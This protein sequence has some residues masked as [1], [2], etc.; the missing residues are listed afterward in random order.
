MK[1]LVTISLLVA[2]PLAVL[3]WVSH[4]VDAGLKK[5]KLPYSAI[6]EIFNGQVNADDF[7]AGDDREEH[8]DLDV[9]L[10]F[11]DVVG[12]VV[13][14]RVTGRGGGAHG[15]IGTDYFRYSSR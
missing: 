4:I 14:D 1:K 3:W 6:N 7:D 10:V 15:W 9:D 11:A 5:A 13:C 2:I 8:R 12:I